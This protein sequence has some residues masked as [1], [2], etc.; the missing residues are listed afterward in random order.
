MPNWKGAATQG[1]TG[2]G[3]GFMFGMAK[4]AKVLVQFLADAGMVLGNAEAQEKK[5]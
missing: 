1:A 4:P 3:T 5:P 2:A